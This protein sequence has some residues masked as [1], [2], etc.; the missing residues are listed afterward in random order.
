LSVSPPDRSVVD[1]RAAGAV[2][3][4]GWPSLQPARPMSASTSVAAARLHLW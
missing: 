1:D 4:R 2:V 3:V